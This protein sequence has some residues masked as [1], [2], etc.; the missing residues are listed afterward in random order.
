M[1]YIFRNHAVEYL[2]GSN[3]QFSGYEDISHIPQA[4]EYLWFYQLPIEFDCTTLIEKVLAYKG[5][6]SLLSEQ[7]DKS[8]IFTI[9]TIEVRGETFDISGDFRLRMAVDDFNN[10]IRRLSTSAPNIRIIEI[11]DFTNRYSSTELFDSRY[12]FTAQIPYNPK[13]RNAFKE[14]MVHKNREI[15]LKRKKCLV[16]DLDNTLWA[17]VVGED[18]VS[19]IQI[20]GAYP[21][22]AYLLWQQGL[23]T[24]QQHGII[25]TICSK[26]NPSDID[27]VWRTHNDMPIRPEDIVASRINWLDKASNIQSLAKELNI[28]LD[29]MVFIDDNPSERE[30]VRGMLPDVAVP[31]FPENAYGLTEFYRTIVNDYFSVYTIDNE[32]INKTKQYS[33]NKKREKAKVDFSTFDEY[34]KWLETKLYISEM[35]PTSLLRVAQMT[36]KTNQFNLTTHRYSIQDIQHLQDNGARIF[37]LS[38]QD[39]LGDSGITGCLILKGSLVDTYLLSCRVL[40]RGIEF[41]F[42]ATIA[43]KLKEEGLTSIE[44]DYI[45]TSK[46]TQTTNFYEQLGAEH[47]STSPQGHKH[48]VLEVDKINKEKNK[49]FT[50]QWT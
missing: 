46:N 19:G 14:W 30:L 12:Y 22:N 38:V 28:G 27:E 40:G 29:S 17:G 36:Q 1:T 11:S 7:L 50:I 8:S 4:D 5:M 32:D 9:F 23:K 41:S 2:F 25:L 37:T 45:P 24:L 18:G 26:N 6:V 48:Y 21:G 35:T 33:D 15:S 43:Q 10:D 34:L 20:G 42:L 47:I 39:R 49:Y 13:L 44:A 16:L 3:C 31:D